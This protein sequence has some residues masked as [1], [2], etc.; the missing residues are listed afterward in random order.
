MYGPPAVVTACA[1]RKH[2]TS[3]A[4]S[5]LTETLAGTVLSRSADYVADY[6]RLCAEG[7]TLLRDWVDRH[8]DRVRLVPPEGTPFAWLWLDTGEPSLSYCRRVLDTGVLLM[9]GETFGARGGF[10]LTFA[11]GLDVLAD[12]LRRAGDVLAEPAPHPIPANG[13]TR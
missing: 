13:A 6:G 5:V 4:N 3:I 12:G 10:R 1:E 8:A 7:L 11:R 9:P 2:L